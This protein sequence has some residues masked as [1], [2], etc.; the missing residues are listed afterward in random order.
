MAIQLPR[1]LSFDK[2]GW[3]RLVDATI[4]I[5]TGRQNSVGDVTLAVSP[6]TSTVVSF[7]NCSRDCRVF[8]FPQTTHAAAA[9]ATTFIKKSDIGQ[10]SFVITHAASA[11]VDSNWSFL[12]IG[13]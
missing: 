11:N 5:V 1:D 9:L 2:A 3:R 8:L 6:A 12:C 10:G 13:G 4:Q 7:P